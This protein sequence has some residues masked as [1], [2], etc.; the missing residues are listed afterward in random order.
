MWIQKE[1]KFPFTMS[2]AEDN[3]MIA[4]IQTKLKI[5]KTFL[6][7]DTCRSYKPNFKRGFRNFNKIVIQTL[8][9]NPDSRTTIFPVH[10]GK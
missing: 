9:D 3:V 4:K 8:L 2:L 7:M 5:Q 10:L 1:L 6:H